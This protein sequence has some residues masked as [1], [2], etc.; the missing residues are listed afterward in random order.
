MHRAHHFPLAMMPYGESRELLGKNLKDT[1]AQLRKVANEGFILNNQRIN[2]RFWL[3]GDW[4][5]MHKV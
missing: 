3:A 2:V 1:I 5:F 4:M